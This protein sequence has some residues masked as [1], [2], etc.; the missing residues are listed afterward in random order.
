[1]P[2]CQEH[3]PPAAIVG[4]DD[5]RMTGA[6][7]GVP[8]GMVLAE[9]RVPRARLERSPGTA[10]APYR[11]HVQ[12]HRAPFGDHQVIPAVELVKVRSLGIIRHHSQADLLQ[13]CEQPAC[14]HVDLCLDDVFAGEW[15]PGGCN[16]L[17][18]RHRRTGWDRK[19]HRR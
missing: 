3:H 4:L 6:A 17:C 1:M 14:A 12:V 11:L 10:A 19:R 15:L 9:D 7:H 13:R 18:R 8:P 16:T 2:V 5:V